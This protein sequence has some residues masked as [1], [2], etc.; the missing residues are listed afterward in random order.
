MKKVSF[1]DVLKLN[2][3]ERIL[4]VEDIWDSIAAVPRSIK[5]TPSQ[6]DELDRRLKAFR[7][8]PSAGSPWAEVK[9]RI[10]KR[11]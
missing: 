3:P 10:L 6:K 8:N 7:K 11:G 5:L 4:L 1:S 9:K 2:L